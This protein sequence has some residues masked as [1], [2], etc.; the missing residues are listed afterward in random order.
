MGW[1][2]KAPQRKLLLPSVVRR[3]QAPSWRFD[4]VS[5]NNP[6]L[7]S[8]T[9]TFALTRAEIK[10]SPVESSTFVSDKGKKVGLIKLSSFNQETAVASDGGLERREKSWSVKHCH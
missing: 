2:Y 5:S 3:G 6:S 4:T 9:T 8:S 10:V 7:L 1:T